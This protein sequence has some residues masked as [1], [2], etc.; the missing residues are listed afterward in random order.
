MNIFENIAIYLPKYLSD[1][2]SNTL[3]EELKNFPTDGTKDTI[4]TSNLNQEEILFQGDGI[5]AIK[6]VDLIREEFKEVPAILLSNTC[7][8]DIRNNRLFG[9][10]ICYAP[11]INLDKY[12]KSLFSF[13]LKREKENDKTSSNDQIT[14][15]V[16]R[17]IV[18]HLNDIKKQ[19]ITQVLFLP[20]G[21]NLVDD[22]LVF[23]DRIFNID[24]NCISR[25]NLESDRLFTLSDYG[26]Y[27]FLLKLSIHFTRIQEKV[28]RFKGIVM[29]LKQ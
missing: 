6:I 10:Q 4:Y 25:E 18:N 3:K 12:Q 16:S 17:I 13:L 14:E 7:D 29:D 5:A 15:K 11:I 1:D 9:T 23:L 22:S 2:S 26:L 27:L 20:K 21:S 8:M 19:R 24:T 28:D